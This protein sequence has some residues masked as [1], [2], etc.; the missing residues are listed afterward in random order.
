MGKKIDRYFT[1]QAIG[2]TV[3]HMETCSA[4]FVIREMKIKAMKRYYYTTLKSK[5]QRY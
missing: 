2:M 3:K 5:F 4:L 1:K